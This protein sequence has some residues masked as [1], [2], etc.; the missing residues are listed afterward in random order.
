MSDLELRKS[1]NPT[2]KDSERIDSDISLF[3]EHVKEVRETKQ[4][5]HILDLAHRYCEDTKYFLKNKDYVTAFGSINYAHG[6][7]DALRKMKNKEKV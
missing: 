6:L 3:Y 5:A 1:S 4:N 2:K 7:L